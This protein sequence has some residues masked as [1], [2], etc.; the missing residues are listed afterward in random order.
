MYPI[1]VV[2]LSLLGYTIYR[3]FVP[4]DMIQAQSI[5]GSCWSCS[6]ISNVILFLSNSIG[7]MYKN[8]AVIIKIV[9]FWLLFIWVVK[10][11]ISI[12]L[13]LKQNQNIFTI[14]GEFGK[15]MLKF[16]IVM[17]L[18]NVPFPKMLSDVVVEPIV[19]I[20]FSLNSAIIGDANLDKCVI[21]TAINDYD[22]N[23]DKTKNTNVFSQ[24]L[25]NTLTCFVSM[26]HSVF[27][28]GITVGWSVINTAL[29]VKY[30]WKLFGI[31]F[32]PN[33]FILLAGALIIS[34]FLF[35]LLPLISFFF[36]II[37]KLGIKLL[38]LPIVLFNWLF[39]DWTITS[40]GNISLQDT[41][42]YLIHNLISFV[43]NSILFIFGITL[44]NSLFNH[45]GDS[46]KQAFVNND[47]TIILDG[48][49]LRNESFVS[50]ILIGL[51]IMFYVVSVKN[52]LQKLFGDYNLST[53]YYDQ[54]KKDTDIIYKNMKKAI[55]NI[56]KAINT[57]SSTP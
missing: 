33:I 22:L 45:G 35:S 28:Q 16:T 21:T 3:N 25:R 30:Y 34:I 56:Q 32:F 7:E 2:G 38:M 36:E 23:N 20:A 44:A 18:L 51:F 24:K 1:I 11:V 5:F 17:F 13:N 26:V 42:K 15:Q 41:L 37:I 10:K 19:N 43:I 47:P 27:G 31:P 57:N 52:I 8:G 40:F 55:K 53:S 46:V 50:L 4:V 6:L 48:L 49:M 29:D 12:F 14:S 9:C 54:F 39:K